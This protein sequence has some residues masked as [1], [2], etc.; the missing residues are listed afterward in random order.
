MAGRAFIISNISFF[1]IYLMFKGQ[2][3]TRRNQ[4][5]PNLREKRS[6][7]LAPY[8]LAAREGGSGSIDSCP[9]ISEGHI[10]TLQRYSPA[11]PHFI[12]IIIL[13]T[14]Y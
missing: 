5:F 6:L 3:L 10:G 9:V 14:Q 7:P 8:L 13:C 1:V 2:A 11:H 4:I 12:C